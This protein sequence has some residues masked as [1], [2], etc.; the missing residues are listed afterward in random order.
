[1][2]SVSIVAIAQLPVVKANS[3]SLSH[4][5]ASVIREAMRNAGVTRIQALFVGNML[6]DELQNQKHLGALFADE[7]GLH[8]IEA[9][10]VGAA[11]AG[12]AAALRVAYLAV[13]SGEVDV[14]VAM[15]AEKMSDSSAVPALAKALDAKLEVPLGANMINRNAELMRMYMERYKVPKGGFTNFSLN[16]HKNAKTNPYAMFRK[17]VSVATVRNSRMIYAPLRLYDSAPICDGA[18]A[19][20]LVPTEQ[21]SEYGQ[22]SVRI[23]GSAMA[24]DYFRMEDRPSPLQLR[25]AQISAE[26]TYRMAGLTRED[27]NV[28]EVHDA[29]TI[30]S[31]LQLE[32]AGFA[33]AGRGWKLAQENEIGLKGKMPITTFGGLKARG[34]P[35]G[36]SALY[37]TCELFLQLTGQAGK[38]QVRKAKVGM[39]QSIGGV[40][41]TVVTHILG[42]E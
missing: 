11:T 37:Q 18:A 23:L 31:A 5:A 6:A 4:M 16:A 12:G 21:A 29:F 20:V 26:K 19:V 41:S 36:A 3:D 30:M 7:A 35:V 24:T 9:M 1:M 38:N 10:R 40:A 8:G 25:A 2:R 32:A 17:P 13:A 14:A 34:H 33:A 15:G 42:G 27:V 28:F 39:M 22:H